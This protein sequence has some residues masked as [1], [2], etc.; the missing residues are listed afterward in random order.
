MNWILRGSELLCSMIGE[1]QS[2]TH[3]I[4][5][6]YLQNAFFRWSIAANL[7]PTIQLPL[8]KSEIFCD[9]F[10]TFSSETEFLGAVHSS[11]ILLFPG[12][13][14]KWL[15]QYRINHSCLVQL[16]G[17]RSKRFA[18]IVTLI[19]CFFYLLSGNKYNILWIVSPSHSI[20]SFPRS[21]PSDWAAN[22]PLGHQPRS[23][24]PS[25]LRLG[26]SIHWGAEHRLGKH[27]F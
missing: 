2:C 26:L 18:A 16:K 25:D 12:R 19:S 21:H 8:V 11:V 23:P 4:E 14:Y 17:L 10:F 13:A 27:F 1:H 5:E 9:E 3:W 6:N 20:R 7:S 24:Q 15:C 22:R